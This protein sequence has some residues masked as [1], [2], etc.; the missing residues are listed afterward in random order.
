VDAVR[1]KVEAGTASLRDEQAAR[2]AENERYAAFLGASFELD[3]AQM[4][5]LRATGDLEKWALP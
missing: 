5:L 1:A 4:Q 2:V 3:R